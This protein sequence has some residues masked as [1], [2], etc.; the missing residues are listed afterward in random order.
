MDNEFFLLKNCFED[1]LLS[2]SQ[3]D[4]HVDYCICFCFLND[5]YARNFHLG[6]SHL[7]KAS[8]NIVVYENGSC[9]ITLWDINNDFLWFGKAIPCSKNL[10]KYFLSI[11]DDD[12]WFVSFSVFNVPGDFYTPIVTMQ[13]GE[14]VNF[15]VNAYS[16]VS[17]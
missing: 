6:I 5:L 7:K 8:C 4:N 10:D 16:D 14:F 3:S 15:T 1:K 17:E 12:D 11:R 2:I 13:K 9:D